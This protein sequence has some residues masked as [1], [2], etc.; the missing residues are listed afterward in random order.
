MI[1]EKS[2]LVAEMLFMFLLK[3]P[4]EH[5]PVQNTLAHKVQALCYQ[6]ITQ[7][8]IICVDF[9]LSKEALMAVC[10][11][12]LGNSLG[13]LGIPQAPFGQQL[14]WNESKYRKLICC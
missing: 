4:A 12:I 14:R 3:E 10:A 1:A 6:H 13:C 9:V 7:H 11:S 8:S 5:L 2:D